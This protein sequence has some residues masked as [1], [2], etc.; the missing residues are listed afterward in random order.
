M[1]KSRG[2]GSL[3]LSVGHGLHLQLRRQPGGRVHALAGLLRDVAPL[4]DKAF[5][6]VGKAAP[7]TQQ[8]TKRTPETAPVVFLSSL[9]HLNTQFCSLMAAN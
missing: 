6:Q 8:S 3:P 5:P 2:D 4:E 1:R 9:K 7:R